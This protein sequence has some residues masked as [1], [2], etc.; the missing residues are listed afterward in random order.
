MVTT[1]LN[2][3]V[4]KKTERVMEQ[5][6]AIPLSVLE[7][8]IPELELPRN[9]SGALWGSGVRLIAEAKKTSPSK[10]LLRSP[11]DPVSLACT[12]AENGAGAISVLTESDHFHGS[13]DHLTDVKKGLG[14]LELPVL[15]KDFI[16]DP[17]QVVESRVA[18]ADA[19]LLIVG[20]LGVDQIKE[21]LGLCESL[22]MQALV[23]V[24]SERELDVALDAG[25]DIIGI[26]NRDLS[27]F[28]T[29][30]S[31]SQ[32]LRH[33]IPSGKIVVAESGIKTRDDVTQLKKAR[34]DAVLVGEAIMTAKDVGA[35]VRELVGT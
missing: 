11:Y 18:G 3:I 14:E 5:K 13:L 22:W 12:Y 26:N 16:F 25:A 19:I 35:K 21:L 23:E 34:I 24:H 31:L 6:L 9:F 20:I 17:Y 32:R 8:R 30:I 29:D 33:L 7:S 27:T 15:R 2:Q 28:E 1:I 4:N 10:G